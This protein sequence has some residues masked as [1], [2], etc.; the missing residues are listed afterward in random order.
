MTYLP[1]PSGVTVSFT[2]AELQS[3]WLYLLNSELDVGVRMGRDA[4]QSLVSAR[5][6]VRSAIAVCG[7]FDD[8]EAEGSD[9]A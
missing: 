9:D 1:T 6:K 8:D 2:L 5:H 7:M 3:L 4:N